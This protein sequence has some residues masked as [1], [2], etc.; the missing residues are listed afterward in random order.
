MVW[1]HDHSWLGRRET[2]IGW[3][4][5]GCA[6]FQQVIGRGRAVKAL[7]CQSERHLSSLVYESRK[8]SAGSWRD[9]SILAF[10]NHVNGESVS[11]VATLEAWCACISVG[12]NADTCSLEATTVTYPVFVGGGNCNLRLICYSKAQT[13]AFCNSA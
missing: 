3:A 6:N 11:D 7:G 5:R 13:K 1:V 4:G 2:A 9:L 10:I 8:V 12:I